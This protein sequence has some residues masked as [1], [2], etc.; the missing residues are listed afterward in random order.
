MSSRDYRD[1]VVWQKAMDLV[2][3]VYRATRSFPK[4]EVYGLMGQLRRCAVS[5][6]S[7]IAEGQ[8][9][10][11]D[12]ELVRF[13][14]IAAGSLCEMETQVMISRRL[15]LLDAHVGEALLQLG[16]EVGRLLNGL[17]RSKA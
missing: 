5:I 7:N 3:A 2:E 17:I 4:E 14:H 10:G 9:R 8:G 11:T 1:L 15:E 12:K 6:P 16:A 13:L